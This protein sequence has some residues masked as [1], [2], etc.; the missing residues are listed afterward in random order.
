MRTNG[1]PD[2]RSAKY[3]RGQ[4]S[5]SA[6]RRPPRNR[7]TGRRRPTCRCRCLSRRSS[8]TTQL[9]RTPTGRALRRARGTCASPRP[10][11]V[12]AAAS[13]RCVPRTIRGTSRRD[14]DRFAASDDRRRPQDPTSARPPRDGERGL[15]A[16]RAVRVTAPPGVLEP[17]R[18]RSG[19]PRMFEDAPGP[20][21]RTKNAH[22]DGAAT[23]GARPASNAVVR[24]PGLLAMNCPSLTTVFPA[25]SLAIN[26]AFCW[27]RSR[28]SLRVVG[29]AFD[30]NF[31]TSSISP[32][33]PCG[34]CWWR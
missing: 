25:R 23:S 9:D 32:N 27:T 20:S 6:G 7:Q 33:K 3:T 17:A 28:W 1:G 19:R 31:R 12:A 11:T 34:R 29:S 14:D 5:R 10:L 21:P 30:G 13:A 24:G 2:L 4:T 8:G 15:V 16:V 22:L 18:E 26:A